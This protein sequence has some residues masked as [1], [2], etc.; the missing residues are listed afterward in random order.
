MRTTPFVSRNG[1]RGLHSRSVQFGLFFGL[2]LIGLMTWC[3]APPRALNYAAYKG[4]NNRII[5]LVQDGADPNSRSVMLLD[6]YHRS[7]TPLLWAIEGDQPSAITTLIDVGASPD[8]IHGDEHSILYWAIF[9]HR[10]AC[11]EAL[12]SRGAN[13]NA[14]GKFDP[15]P[16][17]VAIQSREVS[18][19]A[20]LVEYGAEFDETMDG[21]PVKYA[22]GLFNSGDLTSI[23]DAMLRHGLDPNRRIHDGSDSAPLLAY[24]VKYGSPQL[25]RLLLKSGADPSIRDSHGKTAKDWARER[26]VGDGCQIVDRNP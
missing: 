12:L 18:L 14:R 23:V 16:I 25:V 17:F 26:T 24:A 6:K 20:A 21:D 11:A 10:T 7:M 5:A 19:V 3:I 2:V 4:H 9:L 13:P 1:R 8:P 22:F 15:R